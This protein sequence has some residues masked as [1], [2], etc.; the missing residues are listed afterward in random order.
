MSSDGIKYVPNAFYDMMVFIVPTA[1]LAVGIWIGVSNFNLDW[2]ASLNATTLIVFF[3]TGIIASYEYGRIA[4]ALSAYLVQNPLRFLVKH[5]KLFNAE[6]KGDFLKGR[7]EIYKVLKLKDPYDG[8]KGDKWA[9]YL[10]AFSKNPSIGADL[11][12]RYAWEKLSR[13]SAFTYASLLIISVGFIVRNM[14]FLHLFDYETFQFG[15]LWFTIICLVMTFL[16]YIEYYRRNVWNYDLLTKAIPILLANI[17]S[18]SSKKD[19]E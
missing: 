7:E 12:K 14:F 2:V 1:Q 15:S 4:E 19:D 10:Y 13:N 3:V 16:T 11:L 5:T 17:K 6:Y 8:R 9:I 18:T